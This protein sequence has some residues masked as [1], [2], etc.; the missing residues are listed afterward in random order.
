MAWFECV[1]CGHRFFDEEDVEGDN[2]PKCDNGY[3]SE[4][5]EED[6]ENTEDED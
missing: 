5:D 3:V 1:L 4:I 2:C 6:V